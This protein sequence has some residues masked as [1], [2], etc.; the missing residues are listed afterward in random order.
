MVNEK[1]QIGP[2]SI[3]EGLAETVA[4]PPEDAMIDRW[5]RESHDLINA[6]R[7]SERIT[8]ADLAI[9]INTRA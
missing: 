5:R 9:T 2:V 3:W 6:H 7:D 4:D 8:A 1:P